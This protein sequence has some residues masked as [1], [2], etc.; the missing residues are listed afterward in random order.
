M[1]SGGREALDFK[2]KLNDGI[3]LCE[4]MNKIKPGAI[5]KYNKKPKMPFMKMENI[6]LMNDAMSGYG[7]KSEYLFVTKDL[8][9]GAN[10]N[11][12][13]IGLR[14]LGTEATKNGVKP[15]ITI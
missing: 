7:L 14:S 12:V 3:I 11:Q 10:L 9:E 6:G 5:P 1:T 4:L 13:L 8:Y 2:Q 15:A